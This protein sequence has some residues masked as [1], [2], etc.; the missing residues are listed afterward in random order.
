M[1]IEWRH[2]ID[3]PGQSNPDELCRCP[4]DPW[5]ALAEARA[6]DKTARDC[7]QRIREWDMINPPNRDVLEDGPWLAR[8]I[9]A[10][11]GPR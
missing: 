10:V 8:L 2:M 5:R 1:K 6:S 4:M 11:L 7:L 9:D 3:C